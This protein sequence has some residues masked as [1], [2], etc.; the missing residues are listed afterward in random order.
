MALCSSPGAM[1]IG[2]C[3]EFSVKWPALIWRSFSRVLPGIVWVDSEG[4][5]RILGSR[6]MKS[7]SGAPA[8]GI[9]AIA[10]EYPER[11]KAR[12]VKVL[13]HGP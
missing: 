3:T 12:P 5:A 6:V 8:G 4:K 9:L 7:L 13:C 10:H 2:F 1:S 11:E